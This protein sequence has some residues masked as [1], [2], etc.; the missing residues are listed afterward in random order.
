M[1]RALGE[2]ALRVSDLERMLA[3]YRDVVGLPLMRRFDRAAF[4]RLGE[5]YG[6]HT[7]VL[8]LFDRRGDP[9][10]KAPAPE[11]TSVDH[12][13]FTIDR[14]DFQTEHRRLSGLGLRVTTAYHD[15]VRWQSLYFDDPEGNQLELVCY[16]A[17]PISNPNHS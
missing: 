2:I 6:G 1:I 17:E 14:G 8:A 13:A 15:W 3:F 10:A 11:H 4:F 7:T 5:G 16:S 12:I 9:G